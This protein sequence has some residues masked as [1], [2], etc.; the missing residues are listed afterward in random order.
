ML[1][2]KSFL[3][4]FASPVGHRALAIDG[5]EGGRWHVGRG[6]AL[7]CTVAVAGKEGCGRGGAATMRAWDGREHGVPLLQFP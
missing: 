5:A 2:S 7:A 3:L 6:G 1:A 4:E